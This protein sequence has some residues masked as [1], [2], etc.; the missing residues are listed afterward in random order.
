MHNL[1]RELRR[2]EVFRTAGLY[3]GI[4]WIVIE[5]ASVLLPAFEAPEWVLRALIIVAIIGLPVV[6]VLAWI[7]DITD[8]GI[9]VQGDP[10]DTIV[11]P[12]GGRKMDFVVIGVLS[13]ALI[14]SI[15]LNI[16][17][18]GTVDSE[19]IE[20]I[21]VLIADFDNQ[22]G[23]PLFDGT[24]EQT[25]GIGI[26]GASF[27]TAFD[28]N[29][30]RSRIKLVRAEGGDSLDEEA[31]RLIAVREGI[32]L[33][34]S[35][36]VTESN[37]RYEFNVNFFEPTSSDR[38]VEVERTAAD[39]VAVLAT[40]SEIAGE[41]RE[42]LGDTSIEKDSLRGNE[43]FTAAS[44]E[45][46]KAYAEAQSVA[47]A[48][49]YE[50]AAGYYR[51]AIEFDP[52]FGRAY[53]GWALAMF[54]L[55][56]DAEAE[57]LW[58]KAL[59]HMNTMTDRE[60]HRTL[61]LYYMAVSQNYEKAI[62]SYEDLVEKYPADGA[63]HNNLAVAYFSTLDFAGAMDEARKVLE[64]YPS[65]LF[66]QQN[67][68]LFAMYAGEFDLAEEIARGVIAED[69]GRYYAWLP[70]AIAELS[71]G[72]LDAARESYH[73]MA[74]TGERGA[75]LANVG[76][77]DLAIFEGQYGQ[78]IDLLEPGVAIDIEAGNNRSAA[79]KYIA[80][81]EAHAGAGDADASID[82]IEKAVASNAGLGRQVSAALLYLEHGRVELALQISDELLAA[83]QP[84]RRAYGEMIG[85]LIE[86][87]NGDS[88][89][90]LDKL[91]AALGLADFWLIR[92]YLGQ[93][94]FNAG[95]Y[96]EALDEFDIATQR[97]GEAA[98]LFQDDLPT[99]RYLATLP[100]WR[101]RAQEALGMSEAAVESYTEFLQRR[102]GEDSLASDARERIAQ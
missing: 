56:R 32:Q 47:Y 30:A 6:I 75:A 60:R 102:P 45:A 36:T 68:A 88:I 12:F 96:V 44:L 24:I 22:T 74:A 61:G 69:D 17:S 55:G 29:R 2:R 59:T 83:V 57:E 41:I 79:T 80:L 31:A 18:E 10:T 49:D 33:V 65:N 25:I 48:G 40:V 9:E 11:A 95:S 4:A 71:R 82:A 51:Q 63:G 70:I 5:G 67:Y 93:A 39:K 77:A 54:N 16:T 90:A 27:I 35:G 62:E 37:D 85:G 78:A 14:F 66:Y 3:V 7:F 53:S 92:F 73:Q 89:A 58:Q 38:V 101:G 15:Y 100:Y 26:E 72:N 42:E 86:W 1:F 34:L 64:I 91:R 21:S 76:H 20:P 81:A 19:E 94:Y 50:K 97:R 28:R 46:A 87:R 23:D 13:V 43:S 84:Q 98:A 99:W 52:N 8:H